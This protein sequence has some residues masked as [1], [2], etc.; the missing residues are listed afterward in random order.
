MRSILILLFIRNKITVPIGRHF[1]VGK[2]IENAQKLRFLHFSTMLHHSE[3]SEKNTS[4]LSK[5]QT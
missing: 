4:Y 1:L 5:R 3:Q 2:S